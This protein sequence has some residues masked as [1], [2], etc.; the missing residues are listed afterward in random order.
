MKSVRVGR[1][2]PGMVR[3]V[4]DLKSE[5]KPQ[6]FALAPVGGYGHRLVLDIYP[7]EPP[8]PLIALLENRERRSL[9]RSGSCTAQPPTDA[10][11]PEKPAA[12]P[13]RKKRA[14]A[15]PPRMPRMITVAIDAGHGGEDPGA[16]GRSGT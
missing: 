15:P 7:L 10:P 5:V 14:R 16:R 2:K 11:P 9:S 6:A 3:L 8:D 4:F 1:F 13:R 12:R